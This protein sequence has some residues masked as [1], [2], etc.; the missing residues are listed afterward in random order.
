MLLRVE[1]LE[2]RVQPSAA[3]IESV[4]PYADISSLG[5]VASIVSRATLPTSSSSSTLTVSGTDLPVLTAGL[6]SLD[7]GS[8]DGQGDQI[9]G[10]GTKTTQPVIQSP[11]ASV[12]RELVLIEFDVPDK[13]TL[14]RNLL[15]TPGGGTQLEVV[16]LQG[17]G[18]QEV[19]QAILAHPGLDAIQLISHSSPGSLDLGTDQLDSR[20]IHSDELEISSWE[21]SLNPGADILL[22]GCSFAGDAIG[23]S[24]V[25]QIHSLTGAEVAASTDPT[26][27]AALGGNWSLEYSTGPIDTPGVIS[28]AGQQAWQHLLGVGFTVTP[29]FQ[30]AAVTGPWVQTSKAGASGAFHVALT[31]QPTSPV[32]I[33]LSSTNPVE[34]SLSA[35]SLS[36]DSSNWNIAQTVTVT[37]LN[38]GLSNGSPV[39]HINGIASSADG[40]YNGLA[41]TAIAVSNFGSSQAILTTSDTGT[42]ASYPFDLPVQPTSP[43]T[44]DLIVGLPNEGALSQSTYTFT[45]TN[46]NIDQTVTVT[47]LDD[48]S[49]HGNQTYVITGVLSSLDTAFN[50]VI[51]DPPLTVINTEAN[52]ASIN[53]TG[54]TFLVSQDNNAVRINASTGAVVATYPTGVENDGAIFG[55]DG[56]LYV[57]D[58]VNNQI[59]HYDAAGNFLS[60]FGSAELSNPQGLAFGPDGNLYVTNVNSTVDQFSPTG[61]FLGVFISA[62]S[63][64]LDNAKAIV[65]GSNGVAYVS[66]FYNSEVICYNGTTG[67]FMS[68]FATGSGGFEGLTFGP[69]NNLYVA[70]YGDNTVYRYSGVN[71]ASLGAFAS[72]PELTTPYGLGFDSEGNLDVVDRDSGSVESFDGTTGAFLSTLTTGLINPSFLTTT[73]SLITSGSGTTATFTVDLTSQPTGTVTITLAP[74]KTDQGSLSSLTLT[75]DP[76][77]WNIP[78]TVTVTGLDDGLN[79]GDQTY[80]ITGTATSTDPNY[81]GLIMPF[82]PVLN[83]GVDSIPPVAYYDSYSTNVNTPLNVLAPGVLS[84]DTHPPALPLSAILVSG[85]S[86][87]SLTLNADGSFTYTPNANYVGADAFSYKATDGL[88]VSNNA[89]VGLTVDSLAPV[90]AD[91]SFSTSVNTP[92]NVAASGVLAND[93]DPQALPLTAVLVSE[94]THGSLSFNPNGSFTYTPTTNFYGTDSFTY[95][96]NDGLASSNIATVTLTIN[97]LPPVATDDSYS[98]S[99]NTPLN[100]A[101]S[102]ELANDTDPQ[103]LPLTAVLVAGPTHGSLTLNVDGSFTY[104]PNINFYGTDSFTYQANDGI[105]SSNVATVTLTVDSLAP[106]ASD[107]SFSTNVNTPLNIAASGVLANDTDP[108]ALPLTSVLVAGPTHGSLTL[109][110]DGSFTYTP[111]TNFYGSDSFTYQANDGLASSNIATVT[112]TLNSLPPV[113]TDDNYSTNVNTRLNIAAAGVLANDTDP[114]ALPLTAVVVTGPSNGSLTLNANGSF[115][116]TPNANYFGIDSFTYK[117]KDGQASSNIAT[118]TLTVNSLLPV[119]TNDR[120]ASRVNTRLNIAAAGV[121]RNDTDPQALPLSAILVSGPMHGSLVLNANGSFTYTPNANYFGT[122]SFTYQANDGL[123]SSNIATVSLTVDSLPPVASDDSYSTNVGTPLNIAASGVLANDTDPQALPLTA[124]LV[125][126]PTHGSLS[127]NPNGSF[128]YTPNPNY[129]GTDSFTYRANDGLTSSNIATVSLTINSLSPVATND[130]YNTSVNTRLNVA[131]SGVLANDTDSQAL[132]LTAIIVSRPAH[133]SL[134]LNPNGSFTYTPSANYF[135]TD[136]FTYQANDGLASS[137]VATVTLTVNSLPPVATND[138]YSTSVDTVLNV[139]SKGVL[140][141]DT[142]PQD[143]PLTA[144]LISGPTHGSLTLNL[145][146]S[147]TYTPTTSFA[148]LDSFTYQARDSQGAVS[149]VA[150]VAVFVSSRPSSLGQPTVSIPNPT[151]RDSTP[152]D[153][154]TVSTRTV[155]N[156]PHLGGPQPELSVLVVSDTT[157][158]KPIPERIPD[159]TRVAPITVVSMN[160]SGRIFSVGQAPREDPGSLATVVPPP[161]VKPNSVAPAVDAKV[162]ISSLPSPPPVMSE[163]LSEPIAPPIST[164]IE[165]T[166]PVFAELDRLSEEINEGSNTKAVTDTLVVTGMVATAGYVVLN[167]RVVYWFLSAL[168]ARPAVWRR[169]DPLDVIYAWERDR[170]GLANGTPIPEDD[171]SLQSLVE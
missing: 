138:S 125:T 62:G 28:S 94:P 130:S 141:S 10:A 132:P 51:I 160:D 170:E 88:F 145:D 129:Y 45:P 55:P 7:S 44:V 27:S 103:A 111:N 54:S 36:F 134:S 147:F 49:V 25:N 48:P 74:S 37:G 20:T 90:A 83:L 91:D 85:P 106:I 34:G 118:V 96:A 144:A 99:V 59:L 52:V 146:G 11:I 50:G 17:G 86:H 63:G 150:T 168:L 5:N 171:E 73:T 26:G 23:Q 53:V 40:N 39:Y 61:T 6:T 104:T 163:R 153:S 12:R 93:T 47:G 19:T 46:W 113:A 115:T 14:L 29:T 82:V 43:V 110:V 169:F 122:D 68:V 100:V 18:I 1:Q 137:N 2:N 97:S 140:A 167:T 120:Y 107:D 84:N 72:G 66:S 164:G 78:Q 38:D 166:N 16:E 81:N 159:I 98:T 9:I 4:L 35:S 33:Q 143:L 67:A 108:Q 21:S 148:G 162:A 13:E 119:A 87:G 116:Y 155:S 41:L 151:T 58:Y 156:S 64:G 154:T 8:T 112:L 102:G 152:I 30:T 57:A 126:G 75:F 79:D 109:N 161:E 69:D 95:R 149:R 165:P 135:G 15:A 127:L 121:L 89:T 128:T 92:L 114:Q 31:S 32:T 136:S 42:S 77:D 22:Y 133:G 117:D 76:S 24:L 124:V 70:S 157:S 105:A 71:G 101:A 80:Q 56:S 139:A 123:A 158:I 131:A 142:D 60:S 3:S 65:W